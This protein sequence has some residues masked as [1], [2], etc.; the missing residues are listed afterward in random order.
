[1]L[2]PIVALIACLFLAF[3]PLDTMFAPAH[4]VA[5]AAVR[6]AP[7]VALRDDSR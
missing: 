3:I 2:L 4:V 5:L 6:V 7:A 1:L